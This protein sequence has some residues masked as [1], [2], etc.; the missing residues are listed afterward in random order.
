[1]S[2]HMAAVNLTQIKAESDRSL[3]RRWT[4]PTA[5]P[6]KDF[7]S[8][9]REFVPADLRVWCQRTDG[10]GEAIRARA[11]PADRADRASAEWNESGYPH[12][13]PDW[14][15]ELAEGVRADLAANRPGADPQAAD[16]WTHGRYSH[17]MVRGAERVRDLRDPNL[18]FVPGLL[19]VSCWV[20]AGA[21]DWE[22]RFRV[23]LTPAD[24]LTPGRQLWTGDEAEITQDRVP[25]RDMPEWITAIL[26]DQY[27]KLGSEAREAAAK[28][29]A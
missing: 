29:A 1:M 23:D 24:R 25:S 11:W 3:E 2:A 28:R 4:L 15:R 5:P 9:D 27:A 7:L 22:N 17:W 19:D 13:M 12:R 8:R 26:T 20:T 6:V 21:P 10:G 18:T 14:V 16:R